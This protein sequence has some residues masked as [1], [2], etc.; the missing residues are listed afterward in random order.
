[1]RVLRVLTGQLQPCGCLVGTYELYDGRVARIVDAQSPD[2]TN[3]N[4]RVD[5]VIA[6]ANKIDDLEV[7][8]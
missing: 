4:H 8:A 3:P 7:V 1:M 2:C 6:V 5:E